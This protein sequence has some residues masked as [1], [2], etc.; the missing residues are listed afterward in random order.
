M[1]LTGPDL[2]SAETLRRLST[3]EADTPATLS[4]RHFLAAAGVMGA[5]AALQHAVPAWA[6]DALAGQI[7]PLGANDGILVIIVMGGGNDGLNTLVPYTDGAYHDLR[8]DTAIAP[9]EVLPLDGRVGLHPNLPYLRSL[10][11]RGEVAIVEGVGYGN[12]DLSHFVSMAHWMR[13]WTGSGTPGNGW[14]GRWLDAGNA[15]AFTAIELGSSI[16]LH[17]TGATR[18][19]SAVGVDRPFGIDSGAVWDNLYDHIAAY[20]TNPAGLGPWGDAIAA[21]QADQLTLAATTGPL[22]DLPLPDGRLQANMTLAARLINANLGARVLSMTY[23][24]FDSHN[25]HRTMHDAR[26]AELDAAIAGFRATLDP[27]L[28]HRVTIMTFSEFGRRARANGNAGI[29][30][31]TAG[32][33]L[34]IGPQVRGGLHGQPPS[35]RSLVAGDYLGA[36]VHYGEYYASVLAQWLGADPATVL[37]SNPNQ[38]A[39]FAAAPGATVTGPPAGATAPGELVATSPSRRLDTRIGQGVPSAGPLGPEQ[40]VDV[41]VAG[42]A[43]L[44]AGSTVAAVMN[45]TAVT[46]TSGGYLTVWPTGESRPLASNLNFQPA[47]VVPNLVV[48]KV[49]RKGMVSFFNATG[50]TDV[51]ADVVGYIRPAGTTVLVP[52]QPVRLLDTR[53]SGAVGPSGDIGLTVVGGAI[54]GG[55]VDSVVLNVTA[56]GPT[57]DS[58]LTVYPEGTDR[59][60]SSNLN[61]RAGQ[62][63]PNLVVAKVGAGGRVRIFNAAGSVHVVVDLLGYTI[64]GGGPTGRVVA[65]SPARVLDTR[66]PGHGGPLQGGAARR[67]ELAGRGG[68]PGA[69]SGVVA[70]VTV[71]GPTHDGYLTVW[72]AHLERPHASNLN[73][74][75]GQTVPNLVVAAVSADGAINLFAPFGSTHVIID[76]VGYIT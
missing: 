23:G 51:V 50:H 47:D 73:F 20:R 43:E 15:G 71:T 70:N 36:T 5:S 27:S 28:A 2:S 1:H 9:G 12:P 76:V 26:M 41:L 75:P 66:E 45:V 13:G 34:V 61:V 38:L 44:P 39:L 30:H 54:P 62:T 40:V 14:I 29:D 8:G 59:P 3:A 7:T 11:D 58:F 68:L 57:G 32:T 6:Q 37:G 21:A 49:G 69:C 17:L 52:V 33:H 72:P 16:P 4:R 19:A 63:V 65:V 10:Y 46:P 53:D 64:N 35:L 18:K 56:T 55:G 24:D 31:G 60:W 48:C 42:T 22:Y 74:G 25:G 67:V